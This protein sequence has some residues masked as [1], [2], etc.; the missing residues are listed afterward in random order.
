MSLINRTINDTDSFIRV[1]N[2]YLNKIIVFLLIIFTGIIIGKIL[3][4]IVRKF[5]KELDFDVFIKKSFNFK[6]ATN[7]ISSL[8]SW[9]IYVAALLVAL[10]NVGL[11]TTVFNVLFSVVIIT[12]AIS[13]LIG[14]KDLIP[15]FI[16]GLSL[17]KDDKLKEGFFIEVDGSKGKIISLGFV[18]TILKNSK[19]EE[20]ILPNYFLKNNRV[21]IIKRKE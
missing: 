8:I 4:R 10:N 6:H 15:N 14:L 2:P 3:G 20:I 21:K 1:I 5:L 12:V 11:T 7:K 19:G 9:I 18:E 17:K 13:L 16:A